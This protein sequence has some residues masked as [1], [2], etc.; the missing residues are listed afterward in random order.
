MT[1]HEYLT[2]RL[3]SGYRQL[4]RSLE[5]LTE[6]DAARGARE[7][8]RQYRYGAGLDGSIRGIVR[9]LAA[10]KHATAQGLETGVFPA[11]DT[12]SWPE[13]W[14]ELLTWLAAGQDRL[15][16]SVESSSNDRL[17]HVMEWDGHPMPLA[18]ILAHLIE[19]DHYHAGQVNL[20]RQQMGHS[21]TDR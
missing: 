3:A 8:W 18:V 15:A 17:D 2:R 16:R 9:H 5:G 19:H 4:T 10:W 20:L 21:L 7:E 14:D 12:P 13:G 11:A 1:L 6:E